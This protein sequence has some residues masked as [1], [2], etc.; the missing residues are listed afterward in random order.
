MVVEAARRRQDEFQI[1]WSGLCF[2][3]D[4]QELTESHKVFGA[5]KRIHRLT[6]GSSS[7]KNNF[8]VKG[9]DATN[10]VISIDDR[11]DKVLWRS[12]LQP[13]SK[14]DWKS[15]VTVESCNDSAAIPPEVT[16]VGI[17]TGYSIQVT[18]QALCDL[19]WK[20][21]VINE[22]ILDDDQERH[23]A[24]VSHLLPLYADTISLAEWWEVNGGDGAI[25]TKVDLDATIRY[26]CDCGR[27][28]HSFLYQQHLLLFRKGW[29]RYPLQPW[30]VDQFT[31]KSYTCPLGKHV[32][33]F[34]DEPQFSNCC[35]Y[36]K[37]REWLDEKD[38]LWELAADLMPKTW[39]IDKGEWINQKEAGDGQGLTTGP[40][41]LKECMKNGGKAVRIVASLD[42]AH[43]LAGTNSKFVVQ[44]H[45]S[46]PMLT[47]RGEKCHIK[48]YFLLTEDAGSW[49]LYMYPEAFLSVSPNPWSPT[50]LTPETQITVKR[51]KRLFKDQPCALWPN[52]WPAS[53]SVTKDVVSH[54]VDRAV[55]Q[56]K[57]QS[58][59]EGKRQ[60]E[61][62]SADIMIDETLRPWLIEC[63]FGCVMFDPKIDQPLTTVGL[64]TYQR[65]YDTQGEACEVNDH[66]M[67]GDTVTLVFEDET[68]CKKKV[69]WESIGTYSMQ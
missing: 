47:K 50:D 10:F 67:I 37:G 40:F 24:I 53:Y 4:Y 36:V 52:G 7:S 54:V 61:I 45:V 69:K 8:F 42:A 60:F 38:K 44:K 18:V 55:K 41:F 64:K 30:Y 22:C 2:S 46:D 20:V 63:N 1:V 13:P 58:R 57:L 33:D 32:I 59:G 3:G 35:M 6:G 12:G 14:E 16:V 29:A 49:K 21:S 43:E 9:E 68:P 26:F 39:L 56:G 27:G 5:L 51:T 11:Y 48:G 23:Q 25:A 17:R 34:C 31:G 65:L 28:G 15:C 19:G 62:F 66:V